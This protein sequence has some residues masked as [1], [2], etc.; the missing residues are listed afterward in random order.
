MTTHVNDSSVWRQLT[1]VHV[2]DSGVWRRITEIH[3]N[4]GGTWRQVFS[5]DTLQLTVTTVN[6]VLVGGPAVAGWRLHTDGQLYRRINAGGY[7]AQSNWIT[8]TSSAANYE[9]RWNGIGTDPD[10]NPGGENTWLPLTSIRTWETTS[11]VNAQ[12]IRQFNIEIGLLGTSTA[13][14]GPTTITLN[15]DGNP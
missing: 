3:V 6:A 11:P 8:P 7:I 4:D 14:I 13:L 5:G 12:E 2:N 9:C 15:A 10:V 1:E